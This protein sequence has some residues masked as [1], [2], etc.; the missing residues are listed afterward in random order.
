M[1]LGYLWLNAGLPVQLFGMSIWLGSVPNF[2]KL[3]QW[4][5]EPSVKKLQ[6]KW[7]KY[8]YK[9]GAKGKKG[10]EIKVKVGKRAKAKETK[11]KRKTKK[12]KKGNTET[13]D[14]FYDYRP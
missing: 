6:R 10:R 9:S 13:A 3:W 5:R 1:V 11:E 14:R 4:E 7:W 2:A 8:F 12:S